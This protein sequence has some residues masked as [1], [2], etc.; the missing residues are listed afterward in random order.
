MATS[1][2]KRK[3]FSLSTLFSILLA[4][5][6][7]VLAILNDP[8]DTDIVYVELAANSKTGGVKATP[9]TIE[10]MEKKFPNAGLKLA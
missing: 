1:S 9:I 5:M 8:N 6:P 4:V 3:K 2:S 10:N 7:E